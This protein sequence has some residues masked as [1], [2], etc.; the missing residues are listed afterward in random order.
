MDCES[1]SLTAVAENPPTAVF[2]SQLEQTKP[3]PPWRETSAAAQDRFASRRNLAAH[4]GQNHPAVPD[5]FGK[6]RR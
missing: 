4:Y 3:D 2:R 5:R 6:S 1:D